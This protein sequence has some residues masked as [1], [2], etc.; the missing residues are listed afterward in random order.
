[1]KKFGP[2]ETFDVLE[3]K[4]VP[5]DE[6]LSDLLVGPSD[7]HLVV[8]VRLLCQAHAEVDRNSQ[9]HSLPVG[10][11]QDAKLLKGTKK[12]TL[13]PMLITKRLKVYYHSGSNSP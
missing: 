8:V 7:E 11:E 10:F 1:M 2:V 12:L 13:K 6:G 4:H 9:V 5:L 3:V